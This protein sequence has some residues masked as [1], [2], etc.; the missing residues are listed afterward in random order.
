MAWDSWR[1]RFVVTVQVI[2]RWRRLIHRID[3][4]FW[5]AAIRKMIDTNNAMESLHRALRKLIKARGSSSSEEIAAKLL[6]LA[7]RNAGGPLAAPC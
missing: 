6:F 1:R 4:R 3:E 5:R 2:H 7:I